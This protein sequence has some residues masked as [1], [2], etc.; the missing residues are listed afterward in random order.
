ME[1]EPGATV[2][3]SLV[4]RVS[5]SM[6]CIALALECTGSGHKHEV[7]KKKKSMSTERN[8]HGACLLCSYAIKVEVWSQLLVARVEDKNI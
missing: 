2:P 1:V 3:V 5:T 6:I 7:F 8:E 4:C